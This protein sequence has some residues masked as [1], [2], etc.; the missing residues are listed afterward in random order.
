MS[1]KRILIV[2]DTKEIGRMIQ[3]ALETLD[4]TL[5]V[6]VLTNAEDALLALPRQ[7]IDLLVVDVRL[8]GISGL[9]LTRKLRARRQNAKVIQISGI[10]DPHLRDQAIEMGADLFLSKPLV[11]GE[12]LTAVQELLGLEKSRVG[13]PPSASV[14][15]QL[16]GLRSRLGAAAAVLVDAHGRLAAR[17]GDLPQGWAAVTADAATGEDTAGSITLETN[18]GVSLA[19]CL[20]AAEKVNPLLGNRSGE[21]ALVLRGEAFDLVAAPVTGAFRLLV[22][23]NRSASTVRLAIALDEVLVAQKNLE[24]ALLEMPLAEPTFAPGKS[25]AARPATAP[26]AKTVPV[27]AGAAAP[28]APEMVK[29]S[30]SAKGPA[31]VEDERLARELETLIRKPGKGALKPAEVETFWEQLSTRSEGAQQDDPDMLSFDQ[32]RQMGLAPRETD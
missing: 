16:A 15:D 9:E 32:A 30:G 25:E 22:V 20:A 23:L 3:A 21:K 7:P 17:E 8:P 10:N 28:R 12:F 5:Q 4:A 1:G 27:I 31:P 24:K 18:L 14:A 6:N 2:D 11:M 26:I 19:E 29:S 13:S